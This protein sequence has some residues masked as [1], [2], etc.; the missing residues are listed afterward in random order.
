[1]RKETPFYLFH[2][3]DAHSTLKAM[4][5]SIWRTPAGVI[6][7]IDLSDSAMWRRESNRQR[8]IALKLAKEYQVIAKARRAKDHYD[9]LSPS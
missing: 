6:R 3:W 4:T 9:G 8:E 1:M 2:G 7:A 5:E